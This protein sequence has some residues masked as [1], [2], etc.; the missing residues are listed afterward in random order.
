MV[1]ATELEGRRP[2]LFQWLDPP[3]EFHKNLPVGSNV[4][5][6]EHGQTVSMV[7]S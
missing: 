5:K 7:I 6:W 3:T 4:I 2:G 1:E